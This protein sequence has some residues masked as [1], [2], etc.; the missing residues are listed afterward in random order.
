[1]KQ[2]KRPPEEP[3]IDQ[4]DLEYYPYQH[5]FLYQKII[6]S[7]SLCRFLRLK[8]DGQGY[9]L[10]Q[11]LKKEVHELGIFNSKYLKNI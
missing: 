6:A 1:M 8:P 9:L 10:H 2:N 11:H 3:N 7:F 4:S 5:F